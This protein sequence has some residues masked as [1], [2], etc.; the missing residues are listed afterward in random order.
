MKI[1]A[2]FSDGLQQQLQGRA[3]GDEFSITAHARI[4]GGEEVLVDVSQMGE[5]DPQFIQGDLE[6]HLLLSHGVIKP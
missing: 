1:T 3:I 4:V 2:T 5:Q 6:V